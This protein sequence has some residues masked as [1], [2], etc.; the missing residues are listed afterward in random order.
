MPPAHPAK[1]AEL[2]SMNTALETASHPSAPLLPTCTPV[3]AAGGAVMIKML[4]SQPGELFEHQQG[5]QLIYAE[6]TIQIHC[7]VC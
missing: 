7:C 5:R 2:R 1:Q 6:I 4:R 3:L